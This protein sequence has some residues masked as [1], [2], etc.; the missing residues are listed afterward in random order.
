MDGKMKKGLFIALL[1]GVVFASCDN[2]N[3]DNIIENNDA[4]G[5][6]TFIV[7]SDNSETRAVFNGTNGSLWKATD[8]IG[9]IATYGRYGYV[10]DETIQPF[11]ISNAGDAET[12][13]IGEFTGALTDKGSKTY[14]YYAYT[15]YS[16]NVS[17]ENLEEVPCTLPA[18]QYP[19]AI[20]WDSD[21]DYM[22]AYPIEQTSDN[23]GGNDDIGFRFTR[24]FGMLRLSFDESWT[25]LYGDKAV[26]RVTITAGGSDKLAGDFTLDIMNEPSES[27]KQI[28]RYTMGNNAV[29]AITLD[30]TDKNIL[31]KDLQAYFM[32][33]PGSYESVEIVVALDGVVITAN[34]TNLTVTRGSLL[35]APVSKKAED[36]VIDTSVIEITTPGALDTIINNMGVSVDEITELKL[37]GSINGTDVKTIRS[38]SNLVALNLSE[39]TIVRGGVAYYSTYY[40]SY[41]TTDNMVGDCMFISMS[42]LQT[43]VLPNGITSIGEYAFSGCSNLANINIPESVT[44]VDNTAFMN[45]SRLPIEN[46]VRYA[47]TYVIEAVDKTQTSYI[48]KENTRFIGSA[49]FQNCSE[50]ESFTIPKNITAINNYTFSGCSSLNNVSMPNSVASIG[51]Y[52]FSGCSS[53]NNVSIP[54]SVTSIGEYAFNE[55]SSLNNITIPN[56]ITSIETSTFRKCS[57]LITISLPDCITHI[58]RNAFSGC[59]LTTFT[60]P[61]SLTTI[62]DSALGGCP[63]ETL[64]CNTD[65]EF[66]VLADDDYSYYN[67]RGLGNS[68]KA[69]AKIEG[70]YASSDNRFLIVRNEVCAFAGKESTDLSI[71]INNK[72][73]HSYV[74]SSC[75]LKSL[76][77][78]NCTVRTGALSST[79]IVTLKLEDTTV[80][81]KAVSGSIENLYINNGCDIAYEAFS[82]SCN[83]MYIDTSYIDGDYSDDYWPPFYYMYFN[84]ITFGVNVKYIQTR[85]LGQ[86]DIVYC[87]STTPPVLEEYPWVYSG[88]THIYVPSTKVSTY[89]NAS[90]WK[91]YASIIEGY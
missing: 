26:K 17:S 28:V 55:C 66:T 58:G 8:K 38:M 5:K 20:S 88:P 23:V 85:S 87:E 51:D 30:Y 41:Y 2:N 48:L 9:V 37:L 39:A 78:K 82:G 46:N 45:C 70:K 75:E 61:I 76:T 53:L 77:L 12:V 13:E 19:T 69:L 86:V 72:Y 81:E 7:S 40:D 6:R 35:S 27:S 68:S 3:L 18:T 22:V 32:L 1:C 59:G 89:K 79:K 64:I 67:W 49:A 10:T 74:F 16:E 36:E 15:P 31:F 11:A 44:T 29:N 14:V 91:S 25:N 80:H 60:F 43:I 56:S 50:L 21:A 71:T 73:I 54:N 90:G 34:R 83:S 47:D 33:N 4:F 62:G 57:N 63:I 52:A 65:S 84:K 24:V 42:N